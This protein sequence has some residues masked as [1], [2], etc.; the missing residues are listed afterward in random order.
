MGG[1]TAMY[2]ALKY[3]D[4][5]N[6]LIVVESCP[7]KNNCLEMKTRLFNFLK[8]MLYL[9]VK[10][11][12]EL[13][14]ARKQIYQQSVRFLKNYECRKFLATKLTKKTD[15]RFEWQSHAPT[16]MRSFNDIFN[17]PDTKNLKYLGPTLL[18]SREGCNFVNTYGIQAMKAKFPNMTQVTL[19]KKKNLLEARD[20]EIFVKNI[21]NFI[22]YDPYID[23]YS[24]G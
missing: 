20:S 17:F 11:Q 16:L 3:P 12:Q 13:S 23:D 7:M 24:T 5:V 2:F 18:F 14:T 6:Q 4:Y 1:K 15:G 9:K 8:C 19:P 22:N 10:N 21:L